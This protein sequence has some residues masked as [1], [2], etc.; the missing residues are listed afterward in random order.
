MYKLLRGRA[1]SRF[2]LFSP[3]LL[4]PGW[5][6]SGWTV[7]GGWLIPGLDLSPRAAPVIDGGF[8]E[9]FS[10]D[11][12]GFSDSVTVIARGVMQMESGFGWSGTSDGERT[13]TGG[14]PMLRLGVG[15]R[16]EIRIAGDGFRWL[17]Q[18]SAGAK[19]RTGGVTDPSVG[20]K[21]RLVSERHRGP[22]LSAI[23]MLSLPLGHTRF[24]NSGVDPTIKLAW[25][26]SLNHGITAGGNFNAATPTDGDGRYLQ[27]SVSGQVSRAAWGKW[28]GFGEAY[29]VM[30][31][32]RRAATLWAVDAGWSR[33]VGKDAQFDVSMGQQCSVS[34]RGWFVSAGF[35]MRRQ[36]SSGFSN[37]P[38]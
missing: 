18:K 7:G 19:V 35:V 37:R 34:G 24:K 4:A 26:R 28:S 32:V 22:A 8:E 25:S 20:V 14:S 11:R 38:Q 17:S 3:M 30:Q 29:L 27:R 31:P 13:L 21:V 12:P 5:A 15:H 6:S 16:T 1:L 2:L 36:I 10:S 33:P 23:L 9:P